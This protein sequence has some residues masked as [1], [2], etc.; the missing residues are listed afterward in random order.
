MDDSSFALS[1]RLRVLHH[2]GIRFVMADV[3]A[4]SPV[5]LLSAPPWSEFA[6]KL[7]PSVKSLWAY[8]ALGYDLTGRASKERGMLWRTMI[9][10]MDLPKGFVGFFPFALPVDDVS[11]SYPDHFF[12]AL[13]VYAPPTV[14]IFGDDP[15]V[16]RL[17]SL[18]SSSTV[19]SQPIRIVSAPSPD[20]L[21]GLTPEALEQQA[22]QL[23]SEI[24]PVS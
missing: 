20:A 17:T 22:L 23:L 12:Q 9:R 4:P 13:T 11:V 1:E 3:P 24:S 15:F 8:S 14:I 21:L 16:S 2:A 6:A 10:F 18:V 7:P 5:T 19:F